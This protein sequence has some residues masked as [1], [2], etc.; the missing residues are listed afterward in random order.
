MR[1]RTAELKVN[2]HRLII[3]TFHAC[4][5]VNGDSPSGI[6]VHASYESV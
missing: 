5:L 2:E 6:S 4:I 3:R 1:D